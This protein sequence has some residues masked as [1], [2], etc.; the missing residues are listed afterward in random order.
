MYFHSVSRD[1]ALHIP[2]GLNLLHSLEEEWHT[3]NKLIFF[4]WCPNPVNYRLLQGSCSSKQTA[5]IIQDLPNKAD[6]H[7]IWILRN[8]LSGCG[9]SHLNE[10]VLHHYSQGKANQSL[11]LL[12]CC[13][14]GA[15]K[16]SETK[17]YRREVLRIGWKATFGGK[18]S[19][20]G[21][22]QRNLPERR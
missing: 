1:K 9:S 22:F 19:C 16:Q 18:A 20:Q 12:S 6:V 4:S 2:W 15:G 21:L 5:S 7:M 13:S 3:G 10:Y 8:M 14:G 11:P 17:Q